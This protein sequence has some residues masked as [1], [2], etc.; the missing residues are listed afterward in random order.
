MLAGFSNRGV[1]N[2]QAP[3]TGGTS[4]TGVGG[5]SSFGAIDTTTTQNLK[6]FWIL[7]TATD[8]MTVENIVVEL[9]PGVP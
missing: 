3:L 1:T 4:A 8:T 5:V 7:A 9:L 2:V 6:A